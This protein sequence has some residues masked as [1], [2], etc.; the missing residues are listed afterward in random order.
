MFKASGNNVLQKLIDMT[1]KKVKSLKNKHQSIYDEWEEKILDPLGSGSDYTVFLDH[2]GIPCLDIRFEPKEYSEYGTYHSVYDSFAWMDH[3]G[4]KGFYYHVK[5]TEIVLKIIKNVVNVKYLPFDHNNQAKMFI[6]DI[7]KIKFNNLNNELIKNKTNIL[8][9]SLHNYKILSKNLEYHKKSIGPLIYNDIV[10]FV[11]REFLNKHG[12]PKQ[13]WYKN[14]MVAPGL[15][16]GYGSLTF[17]GIRYAI[18]HNNNKLIENEFN[19]VIKSI[20]GANK[21]LNINN[22]KK[23]N[24]LIFNKK[25]NTIYSLVNES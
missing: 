12:L 7:I 23:N 4:D 21:M 3:Y 20:N 10:Q 17:P 13:K 1:T 6:K 11:E 25:I 24:N 19:K 9:K 2:L 15:E 22:N 18:N 8:L 16:L 14:L 5:L